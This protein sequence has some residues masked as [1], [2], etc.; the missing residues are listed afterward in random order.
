METDKRWNKVGG[1]DFKVGGR[2]E[3]QDI[4]LGHLSFEFLDLEIEIS[5]NMKFEF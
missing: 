3:T 5:Q 4:V 1:K 2:G